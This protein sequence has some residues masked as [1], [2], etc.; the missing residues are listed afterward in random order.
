MMKKYWGKKEWSESLYLNDVYE[1]D[2]DGYVEDEPAFS[3]FDLGMMFDWLK[4]IG[5]ND[6]NTFE[7]TNDFITYSEDFEAF[8]NG[9]I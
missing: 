6:R 1:E 3:V 7:D 8:R 2:E 9:K 4:V 5:F